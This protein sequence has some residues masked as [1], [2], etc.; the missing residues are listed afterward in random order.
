MNDLRAALDEFVADVPVYGDLD[1]AIG[2]AA[3]DRRRRNGLV[4]TIAAAAAVLAVVVGVLAITR[5]GRGTQQPIGPT[6]PSPTPSV[7]PT[8]WPGVI[9]PGT[10]WPVVSDQR[11][12]PPGDPWR[13]RIDPQDSAVGE[14]DIRVVAGVERARWKLEL[15]TGRPLETIPR[16]SDRI[17]EYGVVVDTDGDRVGDCQLAMT[18]DRIS[19]KNLRSG[20]TEEKVGAAGYPFDT[21]EDDLPSVSLFFLNGVWQE[22]CEPPRGPIRWYAYASLTENGQVTAWDFAPDAAWLKGAVQR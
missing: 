4:A 21:A 6:S 2:Q 12:G 11:L 1:R 5:D 14:V 20:V 15:R 16:S 10:S 9:R 8:E 7:A 3:S 18:T 22:P 13:G 19:L 17:V